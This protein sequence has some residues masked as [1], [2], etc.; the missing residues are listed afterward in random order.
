MFRALWLI[1]D[2]LLDLEEVRENNVITGVRLAIDY[3][4]QP[5]LIVELT[6]KLSKRF[7]NLIEALRGVDYAVNLQQ[8][9]VE[10]K[11]MLKKELKR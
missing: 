2:H 10:L 3:V 7:N 9:Y 11:E 8:E 6:E 5:R 1:L 4:R